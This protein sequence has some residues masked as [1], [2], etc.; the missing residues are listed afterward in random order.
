MSR[1]ITTRFPPS[2][3]GLFHVGSARTALFNYL[4]AKQ[5]GGKFLL[6][7]ED[8]DKERSTKGFEKDI[9]DGLDWLGIKPDGEVLRQSE[10]AQRH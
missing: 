2:P 9:V 6:R 8:T 1:S 10:R 4:F 5:N 3:T 7:F